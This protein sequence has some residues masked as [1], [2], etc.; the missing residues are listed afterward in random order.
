MRFRCSYRAMVRIGE[1]QECIGRSRRRGRKHRTALQVSRNTLGT[2]QTLVVIHYTEPHTFTLVSTVHSQRLRRVRTRN[3]VYL[4]VSC[5][6]NMLRESSFM[7]EQR[8]AWPRPRARPRAGLL[9]SS[10]ATDSD[11]AHPQRLVCVSVN[12]N[13][14]G[15][16]H[17]SAKRM[18]FYR[19]SLHGD[20]RP[21]LHDPSLSA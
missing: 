20:S 16:P 3:K 12:T 15:E 8:F 4:H 9:L 13:P 10:G 19:T 18:P 11:K 7:R 21:A 2:S 6:T 17:R 14:S 1:A 5:Y